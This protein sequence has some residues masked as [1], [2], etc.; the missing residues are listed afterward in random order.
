MRVRSRKSCAAFCY[1]CVSFLI[2]IPMVGK[3]AFHPAILPVQMYNWMRAKER[4]P[5]CM[6]GGWI[7]PRRK[8]SWN[9]CEMG[10]KV[11]LEDA[12]V[13]IESCMCEGDFRVVLSFS[14]FFFFFFFLFFFVICLFGCCSEYDYPLLPFLSLSSS[15]S[16]WLFSASPRV[17]CV[18]LFL[19]SV[20][21]VGIGVT[22]NRR[23]GRR[24]RRW[25]E[26]STVHF[27]SDR[28]KPRRKSQH[29]RVH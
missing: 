3:K 28:F 7:S 10:R 24:E 23:S 21:D 6:S 9:M 17:S 2:A 19:G 27:W 25:G 22:A 13:S 18:M 14:F 16:P 4:L 15:S 26:E 8:G 11:L 29:R 5:V 12:C 1:A 20:R